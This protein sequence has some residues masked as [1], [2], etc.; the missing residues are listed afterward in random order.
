MCWKA[1]GETTFTG[2]PC[3]TAHCP[4]SPF[5]RQLAGQILALSI[6]RALKSW[7]SCPKCDV[8]SCRRVPVACPRVGHQDVLL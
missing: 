8:Q 1:R 4:V 2:P 5:G 3:T 7:A 6:P